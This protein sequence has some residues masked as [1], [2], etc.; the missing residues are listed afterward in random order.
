MNASHL[1]H[2]LRWLPPRQLAALARQ[3]AQALLERPERVA[4]QCAPAYP[5][6]RW[7]PALA[8]RPPLRHDRERLRAGEF[9]FL[10]RRENLGWPPRWNDTALPRLWIYN[11]HY[12]EFLESLAYEDGRA[13][14]LDWIAHHPLARGNP[15]WEPYPTSLRLLAWCAWL[16]AAHRERTEADRELCGAAWRS[17]WLQAEWLARHLE[18]HLRANH[19]LENAAA[20][21]F[22]GA[23][24]PGPGDAWRERGIAWL[25][26]ELAEQMLPDGMH[27]ER[28]PMYH[29]RV[30]HVLE[31]LAAT[32]APELALLVSGSLP[33]ARAALGLLCH[34]DG[35]IALLNDAAFGI[36]PHP[37][38][39][40]GDPAPEGAFELRDA[41]YFGARASGDYL[42]CDAAP[43]GPDYQPG[44]AHGDLLS[45]EL[46]FAGQ[47]VVVDAGVHGYDGDPLRAWC[48]STRAHNTVEIYGSDQCEFW[49]TFRVA[50][51][52]R[53]RDVEFA[54]LP[55][56]FRL[57]AWHDGY[58]RLRGRPRHAREFRWYD[59]GV[60]L[61]RDRVTAHRPVSAVS[62][63]HLHPACEI[64]ELAG[65]RARIRHPGGAFNVVFDG[66]GDV[67]IEA[68]TY[69]PEFGR[70]FD[71]RALAFA[72]RGAAAFGFC[73]ARGDGEVTYH[74]ESGARVNGRDYS[75]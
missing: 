62:R 70:R 50:R 49:S 63:L 60:L 14:I 64:E 66:E 44:H 42:V 22:S 23:C 51:R 26:R 40:V 38:D 75:W 13:L 58:E 68:S 69:C 8:P 47:R 25:E 10:N 57:S 4:A 17:I 32:G 31:R 24:F 72:A 34:P 53:P 21:A 7:D 35:E 30:V 61:V 48:R 56:G 46:S 2:T 29:A 54:L 52:A 65:R 11:L 6:V 16:F 18:T 45:F 55:G 39:L 73:I 59:E 9:A 3:R 12:F 5:G 33:R 28:S 37:A 71:T 27:F 1:F 20:L 74:C 41:G 36:A 19:L 67:A 15:G 43:I